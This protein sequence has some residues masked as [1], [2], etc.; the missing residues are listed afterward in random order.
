ML[1]C[2]MISSKNWKVRSFQQQKIVPQNKQSNQ[3]PAEIN[4]LMWLQKIN[5]VDIKW[6]WLHNIFSLIPKLF[7]SAQESVKILLDILFGVFVEMKVPNYVVLANILKEHSLSFHLVALI[8]FSLRRFN[9]LSF[10]NSSTMWGM[11]QCITL[12][13]RM[14]R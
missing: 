9:I 12:S 8:S 2:A 5:E 1:R 7:P 11:E 10:H 6:G 14:H 13:V 3:F 4:A